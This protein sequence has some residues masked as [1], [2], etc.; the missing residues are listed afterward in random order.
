VTLSLEPGIRLGAYTATAP[1]G[2]GGMGEVYRAT[3]AKLGR[4]VAIKLLPPEFASDAERLA[5]FEREAKLLASLNHPNVAHVYGFE[6]ATP[7]DGA[8]THFLVM[9]LVEGEDLAERLKRGAIPVDEALEI[10]RQIAEAL[11]EAHERGIVHRDL[12]PANVKVTPGGRVKVLDFGLAKAYAGEAAPGSGPD[13]SQSPTLAH[14]GT[15]AGVILGTAAYMS[16]EQAR[17]KPVDKRADIW[18]F[19]VLLYEMLTGRQLFAGETVSDVLAAVLRQELDWAPV[20][21]G[22]A[23][24]HRRLLERC[25]ERDPRRR[26][27]DVGEARIALLESGILEAQTAAPVGPRMG[28]MRRWAWTALAAAVSLALGLGVGSRIGRQTSAGAAGETLKITPVTSSG[29][30][31]EAA[32]SPDGRYVAYVESEQGRQSLWLKQLAGG[33]TLRLVP[34]QNVYYWGHTFT[35]DGNNIVFGQKSPTDSRGGLFSIS[36]LGG[37]PRRLLD[38]IDSQ[39]SFSPDGSRFAFTRSH[40]P[41]PGAT[42]LMVARAD[43]GHPTVLASFSPPEQVAN[44]FF[45]APAWSPDGR[46]IV[47]TVLRQ[48]SQGSDT[49]ARLVRVA[50][51][52]GA[53]STLAD[54]GWIFAAQAAWLPD[55]TELLVIA[56][57]PDQANTQIWSVAFPGGATRRVT[58]DLNDRRVLSLTRDGDALVSVAGALSASV[59]TVPL[60]GPGKPTRISRST[61]DGSY[62]VAFAPDGKVLYTS[63]LGGI[64]SLWLAGSDGAN[65]TQLVTA[66]AGDTLGFPVVADDGRLFWAVRGRS[67]NEIRSGVVD[68]SGRQTVVPVRDARFDVFAVTRDGRSLVYG[69]LVGG[70]PRV[71][72]AGTDGAGPAPLSERPAF[73]PSIDPAGKRVAFYYLDEEDRFRLGV[74]SIDG[75]PLT[76]SLPAEPPSANSCLVLVEDG[77]YV[78]TM[79]G[80]RANIWFLPLDGRPARKITD[81]DDQQLFDFAVSRDGETLAV[82]RGPRVRDAQLITGFRGTGEGDVR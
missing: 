47:T 30:V 28:T 78:N 25:L 48:G 79:P 82:A 7:D 21:P 38:D 67:G 74:S 73:T 66:D 62:G 55:G 5:R 2:A 37:T 1:L 58:A 35:P 68:G 16:P 59:W 14:S 13:L 4:E 40:F 45:G 43:G 76:A 71:I 11:E 27:R 61:N 36:T 17:G 42:S 77:V 15:Q 26:L 3:D 29:N 22:L 23:P 32:I 6:S 53:V 33:Q 72:R 46:T 51:E 56:R 34:D 65:R 39:V 10:A 9:E 69:S 20:P 41:T 19:G 75:G 31:I 81:F 80:D 63:Y 49:R 8:T 64:W 57:A 54:P 52:G 12:K 60:R 70:V 24:A 18:A 44:I 50:V